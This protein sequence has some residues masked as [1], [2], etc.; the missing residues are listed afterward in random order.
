MPLKNQARLILRPLVQDV[1]DALNVCLLVQQ[2][3]LFAGDIVAPFSHA[4][5]LFAFGVENQ[6]RAFVVGKQIACVLLEGAVSLVA[7]ATGLQIVS[8][9]SQQF[10]LA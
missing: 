8:Q 6:Q 3:F 5:Q 7:V 2:E 4:L 1:E 9:P 10:N